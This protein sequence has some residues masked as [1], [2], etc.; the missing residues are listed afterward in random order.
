MIFSISNQDE[1]ITKKQRKILQNLN[2]QSYDHIKSYNSI[3]IAFS[4]T[5][6]SALTC[7]KPYMSYVTMIILKIMRNVLSLKNS[8]N[9]VDILIVLKTSTSTTVLTSRCAQLSTTK[10]TTKFYILSILR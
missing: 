6:I 7:I 1:R 2:C 9:D 4:H 10:S 5:V 8:N 3:I